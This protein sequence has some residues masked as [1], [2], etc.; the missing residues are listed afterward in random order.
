[1]KLWQV[2]Y[3]NK[4]G[5][6]TLLGP[7]QGRHMFHSRED[8]EDFLE[9]LANNTGFDR[10]AQIYGPQCVGTLRVDSFE[11][12]DHGDPVSIYVD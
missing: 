4:T 6:R 1:M 9:A 7:A 11:C 2:T 5:L 12:Y 3:I 8:A 10:L